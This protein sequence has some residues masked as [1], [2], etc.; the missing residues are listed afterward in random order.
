VGLVPGPQVGY[1]IEVVPCT[2]SRSPPATDSTSLR[3][4]NVLRM[5]VPNISEYP[6][7]NPVLVFHATHD[8]AEKV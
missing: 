3:S 1:L 5:A 7:A 2:S 8:N 6:N 4:L